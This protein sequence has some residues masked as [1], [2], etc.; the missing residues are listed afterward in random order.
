MRYKLLPEQMYNPYEENKD[1]GLSR[2]ITDLFQS[3]KPPIGAC[4]IDDV[5]QGEEGEEYAVE[6]SHLQR[7][8]Y[9]PIIDDKTFVALEYLLGDKM[10]VNYVPEHLEKNIVNRLEWLHNERIKNSMSKFS[11]YKGTTEQFFA[12]EKER[13]ISKRLTEIFE[14]NPDYEFPDERFERYGKFSVWEDGL[15]VD[16]SN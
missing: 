16:P 8:G 3:F 2:E 11:S 14:R 1:K 5:I 6:M 13:L 12:N 15:E 7:E 9:Y 4:F 10:V